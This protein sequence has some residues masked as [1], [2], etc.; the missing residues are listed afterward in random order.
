MN[1]HLLPQFIVTGILSAGPIALMALGLVLIFKAT[2]IFN[3]AHGHLTLFGALITWWLSIEKGYPLTVAI[4]MALLLSLIIGFA[5]ERLALRPLTG[6]SL[7]SIVLMTLGLGEAIQGLALLIFGPTERNFPQIFPSAN[8]YRIKTP[9]MF[10]GDNIV[11]ILKQDL[12]W[13][14]IVALIGV[15][16]I[17]VFF[18]YT[19]LG[20]AMRATAEEHELSQAVGL[21]IRRIFGLSWGLAGVLATIGGILMATSSGLDLSLPVVMLSA[22]PVV[23]L[24]GLESIPGVLIGAL[25]I[26]ISEG[27]ILTSTSFIV[28][29]IADIVPYI[30]LLLVLIIRPEGL[31]GQK[32]IERI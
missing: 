11:V 30:I 27:F 9:F 6:Q 24:G 14:F 25:I 8:P 21:R 15:V 18:Q 28:R 2:S 26:G 5:I 19:Q 16:L 4:I 17:W 1:W 32:R 12:T 31:F 3:F 7:L 10:E 29:K 23:L 22:F 20:L 13:S